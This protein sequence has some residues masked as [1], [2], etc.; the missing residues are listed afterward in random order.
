MIVL[1]KIEIKLIKI[2]LSKMEKNDAIKQIESIK[3]VI[4]SSNK[5]FFSGKKLI[6]LGVLLLL[7]PIIEYSTQWMTFGFQD[8]STP[9]VNAIVHVVVYYLIFYVI[10]K[11]ICKLKKNKHFG[12][13]NS[14]I[15][16]AFAV[17]TPII[18]TMLAAVVILI[19]IGHGAL[20]FPVVFL[21]LGILFNLF[22]RFTNNTIMNVSWSYIVLGLIYMVLTVFSIS[23]LWVFFIVYLAVTYIIMG[24]SVSRQKGK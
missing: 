21:F 19:A 10:V 3:D 12:T 1:F 2:R 8:M 14:V 15:S 22:G 9:V 4:D 20:A 13:P 11:I 5:M 24:V 23:Y 16:K 7:I 6:V 17:H 18:Y